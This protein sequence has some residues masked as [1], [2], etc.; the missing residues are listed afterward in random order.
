M[1]LMLQ[2][3]VSFDSIC[4]FLQRKDIRVTDG[5]AKKKTMSVNLNLI[6]IWLCALLCSPCIGSEL[7]SSGRSLLFMRSMNRAATNQKAKI[8]IHMDNYW[9]D[10]AKEGRSNDP[11][12]SILNLFSTDLPPLDEKMKIA[13]RAPVNRAYNTAS[14]RRDAMSGIILNRDS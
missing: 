10:A 6:A 14:E 9:K 11:L 4:K 13:K 1:G 7:V 3:A 2:N 5:P 8:C 12:R